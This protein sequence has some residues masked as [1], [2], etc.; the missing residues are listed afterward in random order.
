MNRR[1][2]RRSLIIGKRGRGVIRPWLLME[3]DADMP[4]MDGDGLMAGEAPAPLARR[5][6][7]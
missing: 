1:V 2:H 5:G 3:G 7:A 6:P 4:V